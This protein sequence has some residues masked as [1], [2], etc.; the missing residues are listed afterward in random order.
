MMKLILLVTIGLSI[1]ACS[2]RYGS[3]GHGCGQ[4]CKM[5][6]VITPEQKKMMAE[7]HQ[8]LAD[9]LKSD[10]SVDDCHKEMKADCQTGKCGMKK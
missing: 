2:H 7:K 9:C 4:D 5:D 8:K 1:T 10:K 3:K 6:G